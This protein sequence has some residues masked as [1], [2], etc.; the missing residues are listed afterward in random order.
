[1]TENQKSIYLMKTKNINKKT[2]QHKNYNNIKIT[3]IYIYHITPV[4]NCGLRDA[5]LFQVRF[6]YVHH[7]ITQSRQI[8]VTK[9]LS[10]EKGNKITKK[11]H[12]YISKK[13]KKITITGCKTIPEMSG[14]K[15]YGAPF[16]TNYL[17]SSDPHRDI[18]QTF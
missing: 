2:P 4:W 16:K 10:G 13:C 9:G 14:T 3:Y 6:I 18:K 1:M 5:Q 15:V 7:L 17:L 12:N 11:L 8:F